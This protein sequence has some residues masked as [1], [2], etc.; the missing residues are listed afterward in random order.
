MRQLL[1]RSWW[2]LALRGAVAVLFGILALAGALSIL[3]GAFVVIFPGAGALALL[4]LIG[5]YAV[6]VGVLLIVLGFRV[7]SVT[8]TPH[9]PARG[10]TA[11]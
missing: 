8:R 5:V 9:H 3:F 11:A 6:A 2:T 1:S 7:R 10:A 4:W